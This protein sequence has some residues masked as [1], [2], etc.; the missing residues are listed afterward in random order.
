MRRL[1]SIFED[2][3]LKE[4]TIFEKVPSFVQ[5]NF[6]PFFQEF[7]VPLQ[8]SSNSDIYASICISFILLRSNQSHQLFPNSD[9]ALWRSG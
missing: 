6:A 9:Q 8:V 2:Y 3:E 1:V 7:S 5:R 4:P